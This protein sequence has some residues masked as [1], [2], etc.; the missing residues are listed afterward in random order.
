MADKV[1]IDEKLS[2]DGVIPVWARE[3][4]LQTISAQSKASTTYLKAIASNSLDKATAEKLEQS[5]IAVERDGTKSILGGFKGLSNDLGK[6]FGGLQGTLSNS[7]R[8]MTSSMTTLTRTGIIG[9]LENSVSKY[10][11]SLLATGE[12]ATGLSA[13]ILSLSGTVLEGVGVLAALFLETQ[14]MVDDFQKL[15]ENGINFSEGLVGMTKAAGDLGLSVNELVT[16]FNTASATVTYLGT[17]RA[18][19]LSK[20]FTEL[21]RTSGELGLTNTEAAQAVLEYTDMLRTVGSLQGKSNEELV[22]GASEYVQELN[23]LSNITGKSRKEQQKEIEARRKNLDL[24]LA[25]AGLPKEVQDKVRKA[26]DQFNQLGPTMGDVFTKALASQLAGKGLSGLDSATQIMLTQSGLADILPKMAEDAKR[27]GNVTEDLGNALEKLGSPEM[28][29]RLRNMANGTGAVADAA[30]TFLQGQQESADARK[31]EDDIREETTKRLQT[32]GN[33]LSETEIKEQVRQEFQKK[34]NDN[35]AEMLKTQQKLEASVNTLKAAFDTMLTRNIIPLLPAFQ[36]IADVVTVFGEI[37]V[38][39]T[40]D[41]TIAFGGVIKYATILGEGFQSFSNL[42]KGILI[43]FGIMKPANTTADN[44][45]R[46]DHDRNRVGEKP[47]SAF[48]SLNIAKYAT[49]AALGIWAGGKLTRGIGGVFGMS[50]KAASALPTPSL[51]GML[52][53]PELPGVAGATKGVGGILGKAGC[54]LSG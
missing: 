31:R 53:G 50:S 19:K 52:A 42:I 44:D 40:D 28:L 54:A 39:V 8:S 11:R 17:D 45:S 47:E 51:P 25:I 7:F 1:I 5:L 16:A 6:D 9:V 46:G 33:T 29:I 43:D 2:T 27:T 13:T 26:T 18:T 14:A 36:K 34:A 49:E 10:S 38:R 12:T 20:Q 3:N 22:K 24:N 23:L 30:R 37:F 48:S 15:Y 4:T 41:L 35:A 32:Y 21:N